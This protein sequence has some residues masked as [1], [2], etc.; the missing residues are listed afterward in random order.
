MFQ[1]RLRTGAEIFVD[2]KEVANRRD[3][4]LC[5]LLGFLLGKRSRACT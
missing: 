2:P 5:L 3:F 4:L 1:S